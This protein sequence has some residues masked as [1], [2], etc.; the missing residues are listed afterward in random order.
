LALTV[1]IVW[2]VFTPA[3]AAAITGVSVEL[4]RDWRRRGIEKS[5]ARGK[6]PRWTAEDLARLLVR[7]EFSRAGISIK[8][9][10]ELAALSAAPIQDFVAQI[11]LQGHRYAH[12]FGVHTTSEEHRMARFLVWADNQVFRTFDPAEWRNEFQPLSWTVMDCK[13]AAQRIVERSPRP[14][15]RIEVGNEP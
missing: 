2:E 4:Q 14:L 9:T 5:L 11:S 13:I 7:G 3:E 10:D 15:A 12:M 8:Q 6:H 1:S